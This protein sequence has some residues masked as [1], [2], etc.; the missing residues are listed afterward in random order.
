LTTTKVEYCS[1]GVSIP[2]PLLKS[3]DSVRGDT[4]RSK[5]IVRILERHMSKKKTGEAI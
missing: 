3:I 1:T 4:P 5:F 2:K